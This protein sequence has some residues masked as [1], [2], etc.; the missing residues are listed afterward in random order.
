MCP[1]PRVRAGSGTNFTGTGRVWMGTELRARVRA[2][3]PALL[4]KILFFSI[5]CLGT[6]IVELLLLFETDL[7]VI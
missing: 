4:A 3:I 5:C 7:S 6:V 1:Y 2:G